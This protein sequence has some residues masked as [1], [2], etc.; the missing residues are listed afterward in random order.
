VSPRSDMDEVE[1]G[2]N[3]QWN[4]DATSKSLKKLGYRSLRTAQMTGRGSGSWRSSECI[5][6]LALHDS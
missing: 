5:D 3:P 4:V 2:S 1:V 6:N